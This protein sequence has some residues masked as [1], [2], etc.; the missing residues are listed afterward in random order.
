ME[1]SHRRSRR[2]L[3]VAFG[4]L[5]LTA[6][7]L[8]WR[9]TSTLLRA[10]SHAASLAFPDFELLPRHSLTSDTWGVGRCRRYLQQGIPLV[11]VAFRWGTS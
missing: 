7:P 11:E 6:L 4:D 10:N 9:F 5:P 3:V 8:F 2:E 1:E